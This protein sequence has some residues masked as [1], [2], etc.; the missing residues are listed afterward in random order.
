MDIRIEEVRSLKPGRYIAIDG[1]PCKITAIVHS[2]P[3]KHGGA[4]ANIS[5]VGIFDNQRRNIT[6]P[7]GDKVEVPVIEKKSA[8][9][10]NVI[11]DRLQLMDNESFETFELGMPEEEEL[12]GGISQGAEVLYMEVGGSKKIAQIK[13]K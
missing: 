6:R 8:Q 7:T 2:K 9:V 3:G 13:G 10:I 5:A 1:V 12:K 11:G 4:K